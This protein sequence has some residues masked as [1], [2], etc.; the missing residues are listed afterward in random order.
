MSNIATH[1]EMLMDQAEQ[2]RI[3]AT[4]DRDE[5]M[6]VMRTLAA[7]NDLLAERDSLLAKLNASTLHTD[8]LQCELAACQGDMFSSDP[9]KAGHLVQIEALRQ[10]YDQICA[11][12]DALA[13]QVQTLRTALTGYAAGG[14]SNHAGDTA[15]AA[16]A[17]TA[18]QSKGD[19]K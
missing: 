4:K 5:S 15:R 9:A 6:R 19:A 16:L 11:E 7:Y 12:R 18:P 13:A 3:G 14:Y 8:R 17:S 10:G 1:F 2:E